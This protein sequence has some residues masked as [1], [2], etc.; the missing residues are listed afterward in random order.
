[1]NQRDRVFIISIGVIMGMVM[2]L[3]FKD[4][5]KC[6]ITGA[7]VSSVIMVILTQKTS[8][9]NRCFNC[10]KG[11]VEYHDSIVSINE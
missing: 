9:T 3:I 6:L 4:M 1:M 7:V 11:H 10:N 2:G 5:Y 8:K